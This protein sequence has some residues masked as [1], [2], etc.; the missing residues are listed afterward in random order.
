MAKSKRNAP[1][2]A[3]ANVRGCEPLALRIGDAARVAAISRSLMYRLISQGRG[4]K[5]RRIA[6]RRMI[7]TSDLN[8]WLAA[9]EAVS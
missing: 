2:G 5:V 1:V 4:P 9:Q 6:A 3:N 7:L 8:T